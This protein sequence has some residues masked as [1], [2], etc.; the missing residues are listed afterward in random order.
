MLESVTLNWWA[1][2]IAA[3]INMVLGMIWYSPA[4]F[5]KSWMKLMGIKELKPNPKNLLGMFIIALGIGM[6]LTHFVVY[7]GANTFGLGAE[8]GI[9]SALGF[10]VLTGASGTFASGTSWKLWAINT[11]YWVVALALMG[12]VLAAMR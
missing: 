6:V 8:V 12:G 7:A 11:G 1:I 5:G 10:V 9:L 2:L 3:V 4:L